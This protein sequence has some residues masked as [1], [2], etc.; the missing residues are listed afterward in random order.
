MTDHELKNSHA[1]TDFEQE[2]L[3]FRPILMFLI[4][5]AVILAV[6]GLAVKGAY[7]VMDRYSQTQQ[8]EV[9]PLKAP[10][11]A[12]TRAASKADVTKFPEPRLEE[13]ERTELKDFRLR[14][15]ERLNSYGWV[16]EKAGTVHI[17][18][19]RAMQLVVERGL[20]VRNEAAAAANKVKR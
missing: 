1:Q 16:D 17:P 18:I 2:D 12:D 8:P 14:E 20:L 7:V 4:W 3:G 15:E 11:N 10:V 6:L 9:S 19:D 13:D 5:L